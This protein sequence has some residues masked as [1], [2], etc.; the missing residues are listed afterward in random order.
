MKYFFS[1]SKDE[2]SFILQK[3]ANS[4][5][6][7]PEMIHK[8]LWICFLLEKI[9]LLPETIIFKGGT[10]LSKGFNLINRFSED[11]DLTVDHRFFISNINIYELS[12]TQQKKL[13]DKLNNILVYYLENT[14]INHL[15]KFLSE[16]T[17]FNDLKLILNKGNHQIEF[18]Y[19]KIFDNTKG[20]IKDYIFLEFGIRNNV[21]P[22]EKIKIFPY[23][24]NVIPKDVEL[25][26]PTIL[27]LS[28]IRTFWEK[29]T[30]IHV[31]CF[32]KRLS[33]NVDRLSRHWYD[34]Y[35]LS[36]S[37]VYKE[38]LNKLDIFQDVL[39][40]KKIFFNASYCHY[41]ECEKGNISLIPCKKELMFLQKDYDAMID[42][43]MFSNQAPSF[44]DILDNLI[45]I[46]EKI[47][48]KIKSII[49]RTNSIT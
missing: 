29:V 27:T 30:L 25:P 12:K 45:L 26:T 11:I 20:Y 23:V 19:P 6:L 13:S 8:D 42:S 1:L 34:L 7:Q 38:A 28:P 32:R 3:S 31:E 33:I 17:F 16:F 22:S 10:S 46:E 48:N 36:Q 47:N 2:Q 39:R 44:S 5:G 41:S 4:N 37:F 15:K 14:V 18:Y 40:I 9:S 21:V 35:M 43:G 24:N 49:S